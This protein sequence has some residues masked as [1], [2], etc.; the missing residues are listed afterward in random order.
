MYNKTIASLLNDVAKRIGTPALMRDVG[1][2]LGV[3]PDTIKYCLAANPQCITSATFDMLYD[4]WWKGSERTESEVKGQLQE[5]LVAAGL[6]LAAD[7]LG[8][9]S[10]A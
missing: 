2:S 1:I 3:P 7:E 9:H 5:A 4:Q 6:N 8:L 10:Y